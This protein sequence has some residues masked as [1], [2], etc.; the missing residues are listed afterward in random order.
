MYTYTH[1]ILPF[2]YSWDKEHSNVN[3]LFIFIFRMKAS[4]LVKSYSMLILAI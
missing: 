4:Q 3:F 1:P 2:F